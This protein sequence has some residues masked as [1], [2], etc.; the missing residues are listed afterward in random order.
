[1]SN[2]F[3]LK[4]DLYILFIAVSFSIFSYSTCYA[5]PSSQ[6]SNEKIVYLTFDDGPSVITNSL[7]D[8][9]KK[10]NVKATFFIVG[11]EVDGREDVL[12]RI[13]DEGHSIGL[14]TY[15]HDF[16]KIYKSDDIFINEMLLDQKKIFDIIGYSPKIIRFPGGSCKHLN[17]NSLEKIHKNNLKIYDWNSSLED[18]VNPNLSVDALIK[19]A[20]KCRS[21]DSKII[22]LMHCNS[23]NTNTIKALP[24]IV[25]YYRSSGYKIKPLTDSTPEYYY[26]LRK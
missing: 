1:M 19:N 20:T 18:G 17:K 14:H 23:N 25:E 11:K 13:Y 12:K 26:K 22:L 7:L 6:D 15:S 4:K 8:T 3:K 2:M 24:R 5:E 9:L 16:K 10:C 21:C